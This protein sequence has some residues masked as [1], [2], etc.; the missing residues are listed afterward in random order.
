[1][2]KNRVYDLHGV[3]WKPI[4][5]DLA[6]KVF[7]KTLIPERLEEVQI[8]WTK[9]EPD[10]E[11]PRHKD[12]Y[13]HILYFLIGQGEG[14]LGDEIYDIKPGTVVEI[15]AGESHGYKNTGE[16]DIILLTV[17]IPVA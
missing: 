9:V 15:P 5:G 7:G 16:E 6:K 1:M 10:G 3:E 12:P 13:H 11:F 8:V 2:I 4:R 17:N 14:W